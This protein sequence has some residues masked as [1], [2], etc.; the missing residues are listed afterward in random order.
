MQIHRHINFVTPAQK[1]ARNAADSRRGTAVDVLIN[2]RP[3]LTH[4][5]TALPALMIPGRDQRVDEWRVPCTGRTPRR[6]GAV[7]RHA[8][9]RSECSAA[10]WVT[11]LRR[12]ACVWVQVVTERRGTHVPRGLNIVALVDDGTGYPVAL[13]VEDAVGWAERGVDAAAVV[14][15]LVH[16]LPHRHYHVYTD[17]VR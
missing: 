8:S 3:L 9:R 5:A 4:L 11:L 7:P 16:T 17:T 14:L 12:R 2:V 1:L 10:V 13:E 6:V 15:D